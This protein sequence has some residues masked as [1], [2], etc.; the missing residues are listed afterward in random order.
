MFTV[1]IIAV[2]VS[3]LFVGAAYAQ[4]STKPSD[5]KAPMTQGA[6]SVDKNLEK[7]PDNKGL[8]NAAGRIKRNQERL[9]DR[10]DRRAARQDDE[11]AERAER[12]ERGERGERPERA[13]RIERA[14]RS[15]R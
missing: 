12:P 8:K 9:E 7:N 4:A 15:G 1:R 11:R 5:D 6:E 3:A 10:R 14:E 2:I 13:E